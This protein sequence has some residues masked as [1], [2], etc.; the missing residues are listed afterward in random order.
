[1]NNSKIPNCFQP[2]FFC[3]I[4]KTIKEKISTSKKDKYEAMNIDE[5]RKIAKDRLSTLKHKYYIE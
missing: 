4:K 1:M 3:K 2:I 5:L